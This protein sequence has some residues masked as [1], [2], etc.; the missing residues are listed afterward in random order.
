MNKLK[1]IVFLLS[2]FAILFS[3]QACKIYSFTGASIEPGTKTV[4]VDFFPN[5]AQIVAPILSQRF[6]EKLKD[7]F[8][9]TTSLNLVQTEADLNFSGSIVRYYVTP[10]ASGGDDT[11][12][13]NRLTIG[14]KVNYYNTMN[15]ETWD[16][17]F[18]RF[19]DFDKNINL[20]DIEE[21]LIEEITDQ[22]VDD[23]F[24]KALANW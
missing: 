14:V 16:S 23:I 9:S 3:F 18:S 10:V 19:T 13:L 6:T 4:F 21:D 2:L 24:N 20:K 22:I 5:K 11:A 8:V 7:K 1:S 17:N 15:D 12:E